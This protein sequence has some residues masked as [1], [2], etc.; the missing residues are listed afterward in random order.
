MKRR[1]SGVR[2]SPGF[3]CGT[4]VGKGTGSLEGSSSSRFSDSGIISNSQA[5]YRIICAHRMPM[6]AQ[7]ERQGHSCA[8]YRTEGSWASS[9]VKWLLF[10]FGSHSPLGRQEFFCACFRSY[11][12]AGRA[13][14][15]CSTVLRSASCGTEKLLR[16]VRFTH[17]AV[18]AF[19]S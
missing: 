3:V 12:A 13:R 14:H 18:E 2:M 10:P 15:T 5:K 9:H 16:G 7:G 4:Y 19:M 6:R 1:K 11:A 17:Q 8:Y